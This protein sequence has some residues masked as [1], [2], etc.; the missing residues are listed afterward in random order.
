MGFKSFIEWLLGLFVGSNTNTNSVSV[1]VNVPINNSINI[2]TTGKPEVTAPV[3]A[4]SGNVDIDY[5]KSH[6]NILFID[7]E[8]FEII[9]NIKAAGWKHTSWLNG[10]KLK[11]LSTERIRKADIIFIDVIGVA[12]VLFDDEGLGLIVYLKDN[13]KEKRVIIYSVESRHD[14]HHRAF[15]V[16]DDKMKKNTRAGIFLEKIEKQARFIHAGKTQKAA[17]SPR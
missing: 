9:N 16:A 2:S 4:G 1:P 17:E 15:Q 12:P 14:I 11:D 5:L 8:K 6:T 13:Y 10:K 7:D 3:T